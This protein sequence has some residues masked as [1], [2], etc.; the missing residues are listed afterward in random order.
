[1]EELQPN[2]SN[3]SRVITRRKRANARALHENTPYSSK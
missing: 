1:M 2:T 3:G